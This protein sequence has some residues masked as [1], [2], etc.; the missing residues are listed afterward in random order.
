MPAA[1]IQD[2]LETIRNDYAKF[3]QEQTY[4]IYAE[5][6]YFQDP[7]FRFSGLKRYQ[8]MTRFITT[9][10]KAL[11]LDL[12]SIE[13]Q[14]SVITTRW[15]MS[16]DAPL[17]WKPRIVVQGWSELKVNDQQQIVS[18]IDFWNCS[19]WDVIQQHFVFH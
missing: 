17:P 9:W 14:G 19:R 7:V 8:L 4:D 1:S 5:N 11:K 15:S 3:P 16:W 10:F 13:E 12:Q 18:H 2:L 6:V